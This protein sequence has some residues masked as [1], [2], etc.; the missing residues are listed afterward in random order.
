MATKKQ[1]PNFN[2][3]TKRSR[4]SIR[5]KDYINTALK[6]FSLYDNVR[7]I[8]PITDG[9][10]PSQRKSLYGTQV[11]G[12]N[13]GFL[14]VERL[15]SFIAA[16]TDYHHGT[17]SLETTVAGMGA[18]KYPG[19]N[20]MNLFV[21]EGQFG[22]RLTPTPGAG[23]YIETKLSPYFR[24]LFKKEDDIILEHHYT[25]GDKIEPIN[26][27]PILP[28]MLIN[29]ASGTGTGHACEIMSYHPEQIRDACVAVLQGKKLKQRALVPWFRGFHGVVSRNPETGQVTTKGILEVVNTTTIKI[30]ELPVGV[31]LDSYKEHLNKLEESGV[32][33][34]YEDSSVEEGFEFTVRVP[35]TTTELPLD[36]LY[37]L[38]K[39]YGRNTENF[40]VWNVNG[41]L[42]RFESAEDIITEFVNWRV[43]KYE[44]RRQKLISNTQEAIDWTSEKIRFIKYYL[45]NTQMFSKT[46]KKDLID[47]LVGENFQNYEKLLSM[48]IWSLTKDRIADLEKE[49]DE[50]NGEIKKLQGFTAQEMYARE[51]KAFKYDADF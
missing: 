26:Y 30:T 33:K 48:P 24:E 38:F 43:T 1:T 2:D 40:T 5:V 22:S 51:L 14:N 25:D 18:T 47:I 11:R 49:L 16:A 10:K 50:L 7:S 37:T 8:P 42:Q 12:E 15:S 9:L 39:M 32:I 6:T 21:P 36:Q 41:V 35:R 45:K 44:A 23:R 3:S 4:R 34:D 29:G 17:G 13:A 46:S 20:N 27:L 19:S 31:F 28:V